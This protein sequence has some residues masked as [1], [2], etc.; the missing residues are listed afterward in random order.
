MPDAPA[1]KRLSWAS[2]DWTESLPAGF[3]LPEEVYRFETVPGLIWAIKFSLCGP[4]C[5]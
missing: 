5:L 4:M 2:I 1:E 3:V